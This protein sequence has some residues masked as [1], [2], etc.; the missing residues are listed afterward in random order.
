VY[1]AGVRQPSAERPSSP[2]GAVGGNAMAKGQI[3]R[4]KTNK[5]KLSTKEKKAN[6]A[7]KKAAKA[8]K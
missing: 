4:E 7:K 1:S 2:V 8:A 6:K 5:P 3:K